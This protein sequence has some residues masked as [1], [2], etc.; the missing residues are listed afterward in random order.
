MAL[1]ENK[2][3][4]VTANCRKEI[5]AKHKNR[6]AKCGDLGDAHN[7]VLELD[8]PTPLRDSGDDDHQELIPLCASCHSY[9]SYLETLTPF[10]ANPLRAFLNQTRTHSFMS[11]Q[12]H[13][14]LFNNSTVRH[15]RERRW[16]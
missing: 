8:H 5:L 11:R 7:N 10:M 14:L 4:Q 16:R 13:G 12:S 6:C 15:R 1:V 9:K 3:H 2:R